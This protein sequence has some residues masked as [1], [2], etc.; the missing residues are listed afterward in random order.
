MSKLRVAGIVPE[1]VVDGPGI[2][3]V[4]F[5]QG[6]RHNC[7]GCQNP[8]THDFEGGYPVDTDDLFNEMMVDPLIKG[9]T[10][11]GGDPFEQPAPL[12]ELAAKVHA[13]GRDVIAYTGY[14]YEQ[15]LT[16]G[17]EEPTIMALLRHT[18]ILIDGPFVKEQLDLELKF[19]GSTNQRVIDVPKSL[20]SGEVVTF[21][22]E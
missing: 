14:T 10:L 3:Y 4:I 1:S 19:R 6:C 11:S 16:K 15:L 12:A 20:A 7:R 9:V 8:Q 13:A 18:D 2:R 21:E 5:T 22:F 17:A